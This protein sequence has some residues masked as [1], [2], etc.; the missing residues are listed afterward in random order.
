MIYLI[1]PG[2]SDAGKV[3]TRRRSA[4]HNLP[5][6]PV[7]F[8]DVLAAGK[9]NTYSRFSVPA[10]T[11]VLLNLFIGFALW[12]RALLRSAGGRAGLGGVLRRRPPARVPDAV[13]HEPEAAAPFRLD[14]WTRACGAFFGRW[15][16][17]IRR[18][19]GQMSLLINTIFASFL[20]TG[21]VSWLYY[22]DRLME[23]PTGLCGSSP[24]H[25]IPAQ[26]GQTS[27][28]RGARSST[29]GCSIGG[30]ASPSCSRSPQPQR[31]QC[32]RC[33]SSPPL[34]YGEFSRRRRS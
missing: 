24:R 25:R 20:V 18:V 19:V 15:A 8:A 29:Q 14:L 17:C 27:R 22:A 7:H 16:G 3:R 5:L 2:F 33:H 30:C 11:P 4:A 21:S 34:Q 32:S 12:R 28:G 26:P 31:S 1:A 23:F 13:S 10:F 6:H 9:L